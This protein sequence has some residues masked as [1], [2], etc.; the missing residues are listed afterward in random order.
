MKIYQAIKHRNDITRQFQGKVVLQGERDESTLC[1]RDLRL[2][3]HSYS[4]L[5]LSTEIAN[6]SYLLYNPSFLM[7]FPPQFNTSSNQL[8]V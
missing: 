8:D 3:P 2:F 5:I 6:N 7:A 4:L 1:L